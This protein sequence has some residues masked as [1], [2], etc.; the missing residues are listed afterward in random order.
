M[1]D[2]CEGRNSHISANVGFLCAPACTLANSLSSLANQ[3]AWAYLNARLWSAVTRASV[4]AV[5]VRQLQTDR[6][7]VVRVSSDDVPDLF[8]VWVLLNLAVHLGN[9][10][11]WASPDAQ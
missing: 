10:K 9:A 6:Q 11:L 8:L 7:A 5:Y 3:H 1:D 2:E 4:E